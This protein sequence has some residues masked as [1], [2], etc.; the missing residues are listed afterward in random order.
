MDW[1]CE[2][3]SE[4][5]KTV[6]TS[7]RGGEGGRGKKKFT[8]M[9][10]KRTVKICS[11]TCHSHKHGGEALAPVVYSLE[12]LSKGYVKFFSGLVN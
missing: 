10:K 3:K 2:T 12:N 6:S 11:I 8:G 1:R 9:K 5:R 7:E 4:E